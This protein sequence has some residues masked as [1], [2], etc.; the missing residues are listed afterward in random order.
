MM[1]LTRSVVAAVALLAA[2]GL[3]TPAQADAPAPAACVPATELARTVADLG[4]EPSVFRIEPIKHRDDPWGKATRGRVQIS[5]DVPCKSIGDVA[6][7]EWMHVLQWR[8]YGPV[9]AAYGTQ[10][11]VERIADCGSR[12]LGSDYTPYLDAEHGSYVG[13]CSDAD[14]THA[15]AL[16]AWGKS[17]AR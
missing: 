8:A 1:S 3:L 14:V 10:A 17:S 11:N 15:T 2:A 4:A 13:P 16:I 7:H 6:R 5:P 12:M 9:K